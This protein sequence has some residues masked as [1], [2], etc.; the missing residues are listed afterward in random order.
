MEEAS[1]QKVD[2]DK[3]TILGNARAHWPVVAEHVSRR[4]LETFFFEWTDIRTFYKLKD[5]LLHPYI[6]PDPRSPNHRELSSENK[7]A[8]TLYYLKDTGSLNM[9]GNTFGLHP[10]TVSKVIH[11]VCRAISDH[12]G[13]KYLKIPKTQD[14]MI[15]K[16]SEFEAKYGMPHLEPKYLKIPKT[17]DE[18]IEKVSEFEAKYGFGF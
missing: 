8:V 2:E 18:M 10:S 3:K 7:L 12:L 11:Q 6:S 9:T 14:E 15:E 1:V 16:V 4:K 5:D 17:Q 13:P